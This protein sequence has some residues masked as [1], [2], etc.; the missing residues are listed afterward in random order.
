MSSLTSRAICK[1]V[2]FAEDVR[3]SH[4][5]GGLRNEY[6]GIHSV[7]TVSDTLIAPTLSAS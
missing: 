6:M 3:A 1:S 7:A 2:M 5:G 4:E